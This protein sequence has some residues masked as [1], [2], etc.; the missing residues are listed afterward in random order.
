M[1]PH[2]IQYCTSTRKHFRVS[3]DTNLC[4]RLSVT[5]VFRVCSTQYPM[6]T[7]TR[8]SSLCKVHNKSNRYLRAYRLYS[9]LLALALSQQIPQEK[10]HVG[11]RRLFVHSFFPPL[12]ITMCSD[13]GSCSRGCAFY[14]VIGMLFTVSFSWGE[15]VLLTYKLY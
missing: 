9:T 13:V 4:F 3:D 6:T 15:K 2:Y 7:E 5:R 14:S 12:S 10:R 11:D 8:C 1:E